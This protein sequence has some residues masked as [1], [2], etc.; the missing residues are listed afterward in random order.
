MNIPVLVINP[1]D[2]QVGQLETSTR[3]WEL[4]AARMECS[5]ICSDCSMTFPEGMPDKCEHGHQKCADILQS[6]KTY[7][8]ENP[9]A[10]VY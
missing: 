7:V 1:T 4:K 2:E 8:T 5:W 3:A 6:F 10:S 9:T